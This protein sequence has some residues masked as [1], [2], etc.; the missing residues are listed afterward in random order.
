MSVLKIFS[1][2]LAAFVLTS[3]IYL[4][5]ASTVTP[6]TI[7]AACNSLDDNDV[8]LYGAHTVNRLGRYSHR[9]MLIIVN[10]I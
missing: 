9:I 2:G 1:F 4:I 5:N 10:T 7:A 6:N 8:V 3:A